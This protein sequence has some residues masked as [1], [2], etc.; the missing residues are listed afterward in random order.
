MN[1]SFLTLLLGFLLGVEHA[2][3]ADHMVAVSTMVTQHQNPLKA[4]LVGT[5]W[6]VGHTTTLFIVGI[7]VLLLKIQIPTKFSFTLEMLVGFMLVFLGIR[8]LRQRNDSP[9]TH[10]HKH[11]DQTHIHAH[12]HESHKHWHKHYHS[13]LI[14]LIHGLAGSGTLMILVLS[15]IRDIIQGI[16]YILLFGIGSII[17]MT[18]ISF[19]VG[20]PFIL[21]TKRFPAIEKYLRTI[22]GILSI[23]FGISIIYEI[24]II[25]GLFSTLM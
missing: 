10:Q 4:A 19:A 5:F 9:H 11:D 15:T 22:A 12:Y 14:G 18:I 2:F 24:G 17:G 1:Q 3:E 7:I 13:F 8:V 25:G 20:I 21:S 16:Y 23:G 6:G